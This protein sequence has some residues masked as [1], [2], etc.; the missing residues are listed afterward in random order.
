MTAAAMTRQTS[1][2][3]AERSAATATDRASS[4]S[5]LL[6]SPVASSRTR[7]ASWAA[8]P[9]PAHP[10]RPAAS[11]AGGPPR[12][13]LRPP[14][15]A[16]RPALRPRQQPLRLGGA[17][18]YPQ[19]AQRHF[20]RVDRHRGMRGLVRVDPDHHRHHGNALPP[21]LDLGVTTVAGTPNSTDLAGTRAPLMS[22]AT[23]RPRQAGTSFQSQTQ[24][25]AGSGYENQPTGDLSTPRARLTAIPARPATPTHNWADIACRTAAGLSP[26]V[27]KASARPGE[28]GA[29]WASPGWVRLILVMPRGY[30]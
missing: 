24:Q 26:S 5:V 28:L 13:R 6:M 17:G 1:P 25:R 30:N 21:V 4:G 7:A 23:A 9:A 15:C 19:L 27:T 10:R 2:T 12:P 22:H 8:H 16:L 14:R 18:P 20:R 29:Q 11:P 3:P